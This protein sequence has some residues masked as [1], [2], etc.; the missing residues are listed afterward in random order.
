M[1][2]EEIKTKVAESEDS[3]LITEVEACEFKEQLIPIFITRF[4]LD[5]TKYPDWLKEIEAGWASA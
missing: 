3:D 1:T 5:K 2:I 4:G